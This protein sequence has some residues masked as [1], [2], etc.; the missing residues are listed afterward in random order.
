MPP[1]FSNSPATRSRPATTT[2]VAPKPV[3]RLAQP[4]V[5]LGSMRRSKFRLPILEI[6]NDMDPGCG[7]PLMTLAAM[8]AEAAD[9]KQRNMQWFA[10]NLV[11]TTIGYLDRSKENRFEKPDSPTLIG[12]GFVAADEIQVE[13]TIVETLYYITP[14]GRVA[15]ANYLSALAV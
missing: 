15:L 12:A 7:M 3:S 4:T 8:V 5:T 14:L 9:T 2:A 10:S 1:I 11:Q 13:D 6:L